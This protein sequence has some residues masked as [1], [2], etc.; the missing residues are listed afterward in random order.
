MFQWRDSTEVER[1]TGKLN[2]HAGV[3]SIPAYALFQ[4]CWINVTLINLRK[5]VLAG[6]ELGFNKLD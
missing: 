1:R 2:G 4:I 5:P 6:F 3:G